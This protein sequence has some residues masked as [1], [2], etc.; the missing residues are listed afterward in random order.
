M[1]VEPFEA[2]VEVGAAPALERDIVGKVVGG[3]LGRVLQC[4]VD[5]EHED[6]LGGDLGRGLAQ[7]RPELIQRPDRDRA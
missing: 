1:L 6:P 7:F 5:L 2:R 4:G 3:M